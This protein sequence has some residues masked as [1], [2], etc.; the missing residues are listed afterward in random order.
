MRDEY[1]L[2]W[3]E[4]ASE[5]GFWSVTRHADCVRIQKDTENFSSEQPNVLGPQRVAGDPGVGKVMNAVDPPRHTG[6]RSLVRRSFTPRKI[7]ELEH[8]VRLLTADLLAESLEASSCDFLSLVS[9]LPVASVSALLGVPIEDWRLMLE[10]TGTAVHSE[11][12]HTPEQV[13]TAAAQAHGQLMIYCRGLVEARRKDPR[14]DVVSLLAAAEQDGHLTEEEVLL[15]IDLLMLGGNE[16][17]RHAAAGGALAFA[18]YGGELDRLRADERL[19]APAVEEVLRWTTPSKHV[20]RRAK[21]DARLHDT[22]IRAGEDVVIW[23]AAANGD[24]REFADPDTFDIGRTPNNHLTF[25]SGIH[26]CLG[27]A[28]ARLELRVF[29]EELAAQVGS[30]DV[31]TPPRLVPSATVRGLRDLHVRLNPR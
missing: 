26:F 9:V 19:L 3:N 21:A 24:D 11:G 5:P 31:L 2:V 12:A 7:A 28:L 1:P 16:T 30:I 29:L 6:L 14:D 13:L 8:Y 20:I 22:T 27:S 10:M 4:P 23:Y 25:G 15:F 18:E 17:T